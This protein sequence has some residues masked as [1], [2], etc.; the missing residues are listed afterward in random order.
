[1]AYVFSGTA[2]FRVSAAV[3]LF[4]ALCFGWCGGSPAQTML[5]AAPTTSSTPLL[6]YLD[7][8]L[9][10]TGTMDV[11]EAAAPDKAGDYRPLALK[12]LPRETGVMWLRFTL[13]PLPEGARPATL[14][15]DMGESV[16]GMPMLYE[17]V[18]NSLSGALEWREFSPAQR[19]VLLLPEA[20]KEPLTCYIR[21]D[22]LPGPWF[23][24]MLR[25]PQD[26]ATN[27]GSLSR[28]AAI[29]A[30][31]VVMLLCLLRGLSEKGQWRVWTALYVGVALGQ[32]LMGMPASGSGHIGLGESGAVLAPGVALMLLP[33]V[34][35]H[36]MRTR[37]RSRALD[38]Q[39][40]LLSLPG[41]A[42]ALLPLV[43][44]FGWLTR[45]LDLWPLGTLIF[46]PTAL[47]AWIMGLGGA[48]RFLL[49]C[50]LP[51]L[52]VAGGM[53]GL[54]SGF[55]PNLLASAPLWGTA[56]SALII[57]AT[58]APHDTAVA[59]ADATAAKAVRTEADGIITLD[60][61]LDDPNLRLIPPGPLMPPD[62]PDT[63]APSA[64]PED[65]AAPH[66]GLSSDLAPNL[67][68]NLLED[69]LRLPL[70]RLM[71]E[72]AA[73]G[74][75]ALPPAVR[76]YAENMLAAA[77]QMAD[78]VSNPKQL[79]QERPTTENAAPFN[80]Q[81]LMREA[82]DAVAPAAESAGIGLAWYMPPHLGHMYEGEAG[83]LNETL[84][85]LL[86]S[87]VRATRHGAVHFSVRRVPESAD[88]GHLLF[89]VTDTGSGMPPKERSSLALT[90]AWELAG[91]RKGFLGVE[92]SPHGTTIAFTL[93]LKYLERDDSEDTPVERRQPLVLVAAESALDRQVL[94]RMLDGM[95][96]R[97]AEA[98]SLSEALQLHRG[99]AA[100]LL[101]AQGK[102]ASPAAGDILR[103]FRELA[104]AA[105]L[106]FCKALA[107]TMDD[108]QW[109]RL[110]DAGFTHALLEPVDSEALCQTVREILD[111]A[112][113]MRAADE[114]GPE[115]VPTEPAEQTDM[116]PTER[117]AAAPEA[118]AP[119]ATA[120]GAPAGR[121]PLPDLFGNEDGHGGSPLKIP[122]LTA[123]PDLLSF[124][125]S[126]RGPLVGAG[127]DKT[128]GKPAG[129]LFS[130][131]P[132]NGDSLPNLDLPPADA[133]LTPVSR[134][135]ASRKTA[136]EQP[137]IP[138]GLFVNP[139][140]PDDLVMA[141][142]AKTTTVESASS[143]T[144]P[145]A[146][147]P[148]DAAMQ[149]EFSVAAGLE[150]PVWGE[151]ESADSVTT[152]EATDAAPEGAAS[153]EEPP[154]EN[155][156]AP[157]PVEALEGQ[158]DGSVTTAENP[159]SSADETPAEPTPAAA[160][161]TTA[162]VA[163]ADA[164]EKKTAD[165]V[166]NATP[167]EVPQAVV[168]AP[169]ADIEAVQ[170]AAESASAAPELTEKPETAAPPEMD[171][172]QEAVAE[173]PV[174]ETEPAA[175]VPPAPKKPEEPEQP[176]KPAFQ[177]VTF[178]ARPGATIVPIRRKTASKNADV[179]EAAPTV[180]VSATGSY[181]SP[182]QNTP[183]EWVG[184][185]MP[186]GSPLSSRPQDAEAA[187]PTEDA[188]QNASRNAVRR[189][190]RITIRSVPTAT[191]RRD[192][193]NTVDTAKNIYT[194]PSLSTPGEWVGEPMP[195]PPKATAVRPTPPKSDGPE[196]ALWQMN[197]A[198]LDLGLTNAQVAPPEPEAVEIPTVAAPGPTGTEERPAPA[199]TPA[200]PQPQEAPAGMPAREASPISQ[201]VP[202]TAAAA[203]ATDSEGSG[204]LSG[205]IM[206]FIAGAEPVKKEM[207]PLA[208]LIAEV[209]GPAP[210]P[211][212]PPLTEESRRTMSSPPPEK[213]VQGRLQMPLPEL[214]PVGGT[215][216]ARPATDNAAPVSPPPAPATPPLPGPDKTILQLVERL[217]AAME[218]A[219][220]AFQSRRG[221]MVG[222][223]AGRIAVESDAFGFRVLARMARCVERAA[224]AN[225]MNALKD[226]LPE[227]AVA[228]ER[229]RIALT[230]RK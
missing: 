67:L 42:L 11:E 155:A 185:P 178:A 212:A 126:L 29:L 128:S 21:L 28:T 16:P 166:E 7:Y 4:C 148:E 24:P 189:G 33:H 153:R 221:Y 217:D 225:D 109:D 138:A 58:R 149:A 86:E 210:A 179:P 203:T 182:R 228:V 40:L 227:L 133:G 181:T 162:A 125:E 60:Q 174:P 206:D 134:L 170:P 114:T 14:L 220:L 110:A 143:E 186:I 93:H 194:S 59:Q 229:N 197:K 121:P 12:D 19:N 97:N 150:G 89:T 127:E 91:A 8:L 99:E 190:P 101:I 50:L 136:Q 62:D 69:A 102:L 10:E 20:G 112:A 163:A 63:D 81:H 123:L 49:G 22:G 5:P 207:P 173:T 104:A 37:E 177:P 180:T 95:P 75:C 61:P 9:D 106:P 135:N 137:D 230:P 44:N 85:L 165:T 202:E 167:A 46:V 193:E 122:D 140:A 45:Y 111:A 161:N 71:R 107:V 70:D 118:V 84:C 65:L 55:A 96:C 23:A 35:R 53:L 211:P 48:K 145:P 27:W 168:S 169:E 139:Y 152:Q 113:A 171:A 25:T 199:P 184:E 57:A 196:E 213:T 98:R 54:D 32:G 31:G 34:G 17:P 13:A 79:N 205:S 147:S 83:A 216:E 156:A 160:D 43:P 226:L 47:G 209:S 192:T 82:H 74:H 191:A 157:A 223:A 172:P 36:L 222:E 164:A 176:R 52:F 56:L 18:S 103:Q 66:A 88:A 195:I 76:Q 6:P 15:L 41:A 175:A 119:A 117:T 158:A 218:D 120:A 129:G 2:R 72:G 130:G 39:L 38:I 30:L 64:R 132:E 146:S 1:M 198:G 200:T 92:C 90:R 131:L 51:P 151:E 73:L 94:A 187:S 183:G 142:T 208:A 215:N 100:L 80:L 188:A 68:P 77:R 201:S 141:A 115:A 204:G 87:A 144:P 159:A 3:L 116:P 219:Q 108:S 78:I 26:A 154:V 224:K 214:R 124:A 105:G